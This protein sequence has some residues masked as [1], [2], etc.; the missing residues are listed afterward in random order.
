MPRIVLH[1]QFQDEKDAEEDDTKGER[2]DRD[3]HKI[4]KNTNCR[5]E[6]TWKALGDRDCPGVS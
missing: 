1:L 4:S 2:D 6:C 5:K 3:C